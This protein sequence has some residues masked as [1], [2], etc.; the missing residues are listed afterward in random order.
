MSAQETN[1]ASEETLHAPSQLNASN[2]PSGTTIKTYDAEQGAGMTPLRTPLVA[3]ESE[4]SSART[5]RDDTT[6]LDKEK[7]GDGNNKES[8]NGGDGDKPKRRPGLLE[9][10]TSGHTRIEKREDG[11]VEL[12][13]K[14]V[15]DQLGFSWSNSKKW[16]ILSV[17]LSLVSFHSYLSSSSNL[18]TSLI[19]HLPCPIIDEYERKHLWK[20]P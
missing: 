9:R 6:G 10:T 1:N 3:R 14:A 11:K 17:S 15:Y 20:C 18:V 7:G 2:D 5:I 13:E 4:A 8:N 16:W 12:K 19:D